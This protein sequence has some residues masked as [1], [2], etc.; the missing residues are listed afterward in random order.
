MI[1]AQRLGA[2]GSNGVLAI[3]DLIETFD[4]GMVSAPTDSVTQWTAAVD[5]LRNRCAAIE[6]LG[7]IGVA[8]PQVL[9][10]LEHAWSEPGLDIRIA[11]ADAIGKLGASAAILLPSLLARLDTSDRTVLE[12]QIEAIGKM[13]PPARSAVPILLMWCDSSRAAS[14]TFQRGIRSTF[15]MTEMSRE[16][17]GIKEPM[18]LPA[19]AGLA[20]VQIAPEEAKGLGQMIGGILAAGP[21]DGFD[22]MEVLCKLRPL[23]GE[24]IPSLLPGLGDARQWAK[25]LTAFQILCLDPDH[26]TAKAVLIAAMGQTEPSLSAKAALYYWRV[27]RDTNRVLPVFRN[28][29]STVHEFQSESPLKSV[30]ELG[31]SAKSL[32]PQ[33]QALLTNQEQSIRFLAGTALRRIDPSALPPINEGYP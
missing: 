25:Q 26:Q 5:L 31:P 9:G 12:F 10:A 23:A 24:V 27:S 30:I 3:P 29:L 2:M 20:L 22:S 17:S 1:A 11:A 16:R 15:T 4:K 21:Q 19:C 7:N 13:G 8:T 6:A 14:V 18:P 33:I 32:V 28:T